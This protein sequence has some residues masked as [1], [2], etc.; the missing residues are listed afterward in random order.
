MFGLRNIVDIIMENKGLSIQRFTT[1]LGVNIGYPLNCETRITHLL[2]LNLL[3]IKHN[4][5]AYMHNLYSVL[6]IEIY[7]YNTYIKF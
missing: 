7:K 6:F 3:N 2:L 5:Y 4:C 1:L